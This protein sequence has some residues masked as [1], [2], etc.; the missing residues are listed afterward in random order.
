LRWRL[1]FVR[2]QI[3][4]GNPAPLPVIRGVTI[5]Y[6]VTSLSRRLPG[7]IV[8]GRPAIWTA[9]ALRV[10]AG[11]AAIVPGAGRAQ[12]AG[13]SA[14]AARIDVDRPPRVNR[15]LLLWMGTLVYVSY[16][17][18]YSVLGDRL[19]P[20]FLVYAAIVWMTLYCLVYLALSTDARAVKARFTTHAPTAAAGAFVAFVALAL[21]ST[22]VAMIMGDLLSRDG[23]DPSPARGLA[24]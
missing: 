7:H 13:G 11:H 6:A 2:Y 22:W 10:E 12:P 15:G 19:S 16:A 17:Y 8:R 23:A 14:T 3:A 24:A 4:I 21:W 1:D 9:R 18:A 20:L 5:A